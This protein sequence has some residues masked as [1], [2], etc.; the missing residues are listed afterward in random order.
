MLDARRKD[1]AIQTHFYKISWL[2]TDK[3][4]LKAGSRSTS[5]HD[6]QQVK[7][8]YKVKV[9]QPA[10][11]GKAGKAGQA[12]NSILNC[13]NPEHRKRKAHNGMGGTNLPSSGEMR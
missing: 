5:S 6:R 7:A 2:Q 8:F 3:N 9:K 12:H 13:R 10:A 1:L 11:A 4:R